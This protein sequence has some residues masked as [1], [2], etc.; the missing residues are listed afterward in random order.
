M[1]KISSK[2]EIQVNKKF[3][4]ISILQHKPVVKHCQNKFGGVVTLHGLHRLAGEGNTRAHRFC[5]HQNVSNACVFLEANAQ[6]IGII[7]Q[8]VFRGILV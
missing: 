7:V 4:F 3:N 6:L 1:V 5:V 2:Q 8:T